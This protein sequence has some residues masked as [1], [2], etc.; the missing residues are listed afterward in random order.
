MIKKIYN[1]TTILRTLRIRI[2]TL[3]PNM[4]ANIIFG[5]PKP[6]K[7]TSYFLLNNADIRANKPE[8]S[9]LLTNTRL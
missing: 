4:G 1:T 6:P 3:A 7:P 8:D 9:I 5:N 2:L